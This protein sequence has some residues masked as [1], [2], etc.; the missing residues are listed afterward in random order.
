[1]FSVMS[2]EHLKKLRKAL[3]NSHWKVTDEIEGN[4]Y[5]ISAYW[6]VCRPSGAPSF[7]LAFE[8][9]DDL[10]VLPIEKAYSC[11][12]SNNKEL[13]IYFGGIN[14]SFSSELPSFIESINN[15]NT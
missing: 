5:N 3:E 10:D 12:V 11:F 2:I 6:K 14:K 4:G 8:G 1:M 7:L 13:N 9:L 15:A